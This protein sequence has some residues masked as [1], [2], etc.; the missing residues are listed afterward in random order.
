MGLNWEELSLQFITTILGVAL[1]MLG[2]LWVDRRISAGRRRE[3]ETYLLRVVKD[4]LLHNRSLLSQ[5]KSELQRGLIPTYHLDLS[6]WQSHSGRFDP[7]RNT[8]LVQLIGKAYYELEH[9]NWKINTLRNMRF[10]TFVAVESYEQDKKQL[11]ANIAI[12]MPIVIGEVEESLRL[13]D[14]TLEER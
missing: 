9:M 10:T 13:I 11:I 4:N 3:E 12:H 2:A 5:I 6:A 8:D 7:I 1:G 14:K